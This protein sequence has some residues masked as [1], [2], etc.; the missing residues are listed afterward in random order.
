MKKCF[1][2]NLGIKKALERHAKYDFPDLTD[3]YRGY[4]FTLQEIKFCLKL[5]QAVL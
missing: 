4:F 5:Q 2:L 1:E 3:K